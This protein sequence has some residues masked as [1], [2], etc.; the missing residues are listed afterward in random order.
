MRL[1]GVM[2]LAVAII[3]G[4]LLTPAGAT[5]SGVVTNEPACQLRALAGATNEAGLVVKFSDGHTLSYCV[6]FAEDSITGMEL[7]RRS[8][9]AVVTASSGGAGAAVCSI[10]GDGCN[11]PGDCFCKCKS[12]TCGYW[13][14]FREQNGAWQY[15]PVGAGS[16]TIHNGDSDAWVW[17]SGQ[18]VPSTAP[19]D[20]A[21]AAT[22]TPQPTSTARPPTATPP[23]LPLATPTSGIPPGGPT[24]ASDLPS[25]PVM[26]P[27]PTPVPPGADPNAPTSDVLDAAITPA[28]ALPEQSRGPDGS[29]TVTALATTV[30]T[31]TAPAGVIRV[32]NDE[33]DR[34]AA[35][36][37]GRRRLELAQHRDV[38]RVRRCPSCRR[39]WSVVLEA[40][41]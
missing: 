8:G 1:G 32:R 36:Y 26:P 41:C 31:Q 21:P 28:A 38:C 12:G 5:A 15:S 10:N 11:T 13:A 4:A 9:L 33:G 3:A 27:Q 19:V 20:C 25:A 23:A 30:A 18:S 14:Y 40:R 37:I 39:R 6:E 35:G 17:G 24:T 16:R 22:A 29:A 34:N 2:F 7:L